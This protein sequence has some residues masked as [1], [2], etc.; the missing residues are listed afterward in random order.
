MNRFCY[1]QRNSK[2]PSI[3]AVIGFV[4]T[5]VLN[6]TIPRFCG[7]MGIVIATSLAAI[8]ACLIEVI[9]IYKEKLL[10]WSKLS[11]KLFGVVGLAFMVSFAGT[12]GVFL[13]SEEM[14]PIVKILIMLAGS[15]ASYCVVA[16]LLGRSFFAPTLER[17]SK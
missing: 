5:I 14:Y 3:C 12:M 9:V 4:L 16:V 8:I 2:L 17:L 7:A 11:L 1:A 13:V 6:L 15:Y 10:V